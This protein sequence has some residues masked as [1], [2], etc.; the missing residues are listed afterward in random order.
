MSLKAKK[1]GVSI[2]KMGEGF[3]K[4]SAAQCQ[5]VPTDTGKHQELMKLPS[6]LEWAVVC[7]PGEVA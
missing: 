6:A 5:A 1:K 3:N 7:S 4:E 2:G